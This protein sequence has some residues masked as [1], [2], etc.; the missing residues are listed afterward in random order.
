MFA[1]AIGILPMLGFAIMMDSM[2]SK[3]EDFEPHRGELA[4]TESQIYFGETKT[5]ATVGVMGSVKNSGKISW[6]EVNFHVDFV[7]A[8]GKR[9]DVNEREAYGYE[10]PAGSESSFKIS[11]SREFPQEKYARARVT[12][13]RAKD[14]RARF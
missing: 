3:G 8:T 10:A 6:K 9:V 2:M 13:V 4:V 1:I 14:V 11:F 12:I 5:S 7:D